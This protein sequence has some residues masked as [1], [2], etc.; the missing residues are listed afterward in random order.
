M[1]SK[2]A[3][4]TQWIL[5]ASIATV[6]WRLA[7]PNV[8]AVAMT[9]AVTFSDAWYVSQLGTAPLAS[10]ALVFPFLTLMQMMSGGA[11]GGGTTSAVARAL[12]A[13]DVERA[14]RIAWHAILIAAAMSVFYIVILRLYAMQIFQLLG[15]T[16]AALDGAVSYSQIVFGGAAATWFAWVIAA[17]HRGTGDTVT[18]GRAITAGSIVQIFM[19]GTLTLG[20]FG[21]PAMGLNG[22]AVAWVLC[23]GGIASYLGLYLLFGKGRLVL[24]PVK[25]DREAFSDIMRVGGLGL[26]N[27]FC[28]AMTVVVITGFVGQYGTAALAGYGLGA[29]LELMLVPISFGIGAALTASVGVNVGAGQFARARKIAWIGAAATFVLTGVIGVAVF[30]VPSLWLDLFTAD[31]EAYSF[32]LMY[33]AI[34]APAY[35]FFGGGQA[36]YFA[37]QGTGKVALPVTVTLFRLLTVTAISFASAQFAWGVD[38]LFAAVATGLIVMGIGQALCLSGSAWRS[39]K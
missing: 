13:G 10:L 11:I 39:P 7:T 28:L 31:A 33:L 1:S 30:L 22:A 5:D 18:P 36:L 8:V 19:S 27:S 25:L 16:A 37:S 4:G 26:I 32:G 6:L 9:T 34:A 20:W 15:G 17:I 24:R 29:R 3:P 2:S 21:L 23:Q 14:G 38:G 12:G 35:G